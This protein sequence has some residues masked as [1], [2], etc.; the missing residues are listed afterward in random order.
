M[1]SIDFVLLRTFRSLF[2][3]TRYKHRDSSLGDLVA[4]HLYEDLVKLNRSL[5][6]V[7]RVQA[8]ECV[9]NMG[10]K[11]T[12]KPSRRGD[13]TFGELVPTAVA[14]TEKGLLVARGEIANIQIGT[15]TKILAKAMIKQIDRVI[16]DL[17]RQVEEFRS[18]GGNPICVAF[19]GINCAT[20]Y[21]SYEGER[22]WPTD[23]KKHKHPFQEA[24]EAE[25]RLRERALPNFDELLFLRFHA[26][27]V[28]PFPFKWADYTQTAKEYGALLVRV[29]REYD[30]RFS[31]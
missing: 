29:S 22:E 23:G 16:G 19:V 8:H 9:V 12:G 4:S 21:T 25:R 2:E 28:S 17:I 26:T 10:N 5:P 18:T 31:G 11:T 1:E 15:E 3:G 24:V 27:N 7:Q 14:L 6:L 30:K 20:N 13:G